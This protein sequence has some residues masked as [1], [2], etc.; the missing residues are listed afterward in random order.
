MIPTTTFPETPNPWLTRTDDECAALV[1]EGGSAFC[2][3]CG[4]PCR[5]EWEDVGIG[6]YECHGMVGTQVSWVPSSKCCGSDVFDD[7]RC[8]TIYSGDMPYDDEPFDP[9]DF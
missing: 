4:K 2:G 8:V 9:T 5:V 3:E 1:A 6:D 7:P